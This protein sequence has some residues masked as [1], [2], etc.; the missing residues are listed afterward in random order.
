VPAKAEIDR[1]MLRAA[2][3]RLGDEYVYFML[4]GALDLLPAAKLA[5]LVGQYIDLKRLRPDGSVKGDIFADVAEFERASVAREFYESFNVGS[6]NYM[7]TSNG[8]RAWI[9]ECRRILDR[10]VAASK[11]GD[12]GK[13]GAAFETVFGLLRRIDEAGD[14]V[15][16]FADEGGSWQVGVEWNHV[17]PAWFACLARTATPEVYVERVVAAIEDLDE[18]GGQEHLAAAR[19]AANPAQRKAM[20]VAQPR[21]KRR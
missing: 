18:P 1:A 16:F 14:D 6:K 21:R 17:F 8:T 4:D 12:P 20:P 7:K 9:A 10:L 11:K 3:R 15:L 5:K 2:I 19:K 13:V